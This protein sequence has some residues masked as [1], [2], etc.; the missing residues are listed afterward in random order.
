M[1][2]D[3]TECLRVQQAAGRSSWKVE[4]IFVGGYFIKKGLCVIVDKSLVQKVSEIAMRAGALVLEYW[5]KPLEY[6]YKK[7]AGFATQV[8]VA[9]ENFIMQELRKIDSTVPFWAEENGK[10]AEESDWYWVIDPIDGTTN[11]ACHVPYF[12]ISIALTY[13]DIP[14]LGV[15]YS[16]VTKETFSAYKNNGA[17]CNGKKIAVSDR[18]LDKSLIAVSFPY[19]C[20]HNFDDCVGY[21]HKII[22]YVADVRV[23]G[24]VA[25]DL[26]YVAA[27]RFDGT[28]FHNLSWWDIAAGMIILQEAGAIVSSFDGTN[29]GPQFDTFIAIGEK[30]YKQLRELLAS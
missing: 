12:C 26:A 16:P 4:I 10:T 8:D 30:N 24:A 1:L 17:F 14:Q 28:I 22:T 13:K 9:V 21:I 20:S 27:G 18:A 29:I 3:Q 5:S 23:M 2:H 11:Y 15:I 7:D 25:L 19:T 6:H